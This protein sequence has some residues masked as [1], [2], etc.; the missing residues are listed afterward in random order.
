MGVVDPFGVDSNFDVLKKKK[1]APKHDGVRFTGCG[2]IV[3]YG[4][5]TIYERLLSI[6]S[7]PLCKN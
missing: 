5:S 1:N 7:A 6:D 4:Y 2:Q 3:G